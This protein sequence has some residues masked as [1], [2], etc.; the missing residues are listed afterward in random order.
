MVI[1]RDLAGIELSGATKY[2]GG[3]LVKRVGDS[4]LRY[5]VALV[6]VEETS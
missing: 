4:E 3:R 5:F 1:V 2:R 6:A